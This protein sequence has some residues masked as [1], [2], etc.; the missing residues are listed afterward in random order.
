MTLSRDRTTIYLYALLAVW[1]YINY[2]LG[3][4]VVLLRDE[5]HTTR[6]VASLHSTAFALGAIIGGTVTPTLV[7]RHGRGATMLSGAGLAAVM[8][9]VLSLAHSLAA[10]LASVAVMSIGGS[11]LLAGIISGISDHHGPAAP[12]AL[13]EANAAACGFGAVAPIAVGAA[14]AAG[15]TWRPALAVSAGLLGALLLIGI[16]ARIPIPAAGVPAAVPGLVAV[17]PLTDG[18]S[19]AATVLVER[20][21]RDR[22]PNRPLPRTFWWVFALIAT[23]GSVE[24]GSNLWAADLLR[25]HAGMSTSAAAAGVAAIVGGMFLGRAVGSRLAL[26]HPA[27]TLLFAAIGVSLGGFTLFWLATR[28]VLAITGLIVLGLGNA[29][30]YP[31]GLAL[32]LRHSDGQPDLAAARSFYAAGVAYGLAPFVLGGIADLTGVRAAFLLVPAMLALATVVL[33][34]IRADEQ[35]HPA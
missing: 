16:R 13:S 33:V 1:G 29:L 21:H 23:C 24:V 4:I 25:R 19:V 15:W 32:V 11:I 7:R 35:P 10:T 6:A 22:A 31:L 17:A 12:A 28:P 20:E 8:V 3:P 2:G 30:H 26:R 5:Q 14:V 34:R 27:T 18:R 9:G